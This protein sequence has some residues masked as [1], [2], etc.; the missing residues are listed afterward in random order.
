MPQVKMGMYFSNGN[1]TT[2]Q[3]AAAKNSANVTVTRRQ[4]SSALNAPIIGRIHS[5]KPGCG[6]CGK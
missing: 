6:S 4:P 5:V 3:I 2:R 1:L